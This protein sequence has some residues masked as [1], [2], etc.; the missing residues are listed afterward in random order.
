MLLDLAFLILAGV[1]GTARLAL[2]R[3]YRLLQQQGVK[4]T[5]LGHAAAA[6]VAALACFH[7]P[8]GMLASTLITALYVVYQAWEDKSTKDIATYLGTF[9][10]VVAAKIGLPLVQIT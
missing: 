9:V 10:A 3:K 6:I 2:R 1:L 5:D 7:S 4:A 8:P